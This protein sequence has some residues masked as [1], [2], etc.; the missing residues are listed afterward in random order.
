MITREELRTYNGKRPFQPFR[1]V[2]TSGE[3][4]EVTRV[5]QLIAMNTRMIVV[6]PDDRLRWI[7]FNLVDHVQPLASPAA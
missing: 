4:L 1:I 2:L 6:T 5:A 7:P 3:A